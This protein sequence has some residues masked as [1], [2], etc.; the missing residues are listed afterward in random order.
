MLA[1]A[2]LNAS[3]SYIALTHEAV[4]RHPQAQA[5]YDAIASDERVQQA[6]EHPH[7]AA[8]LAH[9]HLPK[10]GRSLG[11]LLALGCAL[12]LL[13][14]M[15]GCGGRG[16]RRTDAM[17]AAARR[18]K[19]AA[20]K[21][22]QARQRALAKEQA[23]KRVAPG[24][25][26]GVSEAALKSED[27][28]RGPST[29][30]LVTGAL[31]LPVRAVVGVARAVLRVVGLLRGGA[32]RDA[33]DDE[34]DDENDDGEAPPGDEPSAA[35]GGRSAQT[36]A[37]AKPRAKKES[38]P[39]HPRL[40]ST[41]KGF[42]EGV[43]SAALSADGN[44]ALAVGPDRTM[45]IYTG[46]RAV[47]GQ[48]TLPAPL[49]AK[50]PLDHGSACALSANGRNC[51]VATAASRK[52]LAYTITPPGTKQAK[53]GLAFRKEFPTGHAGAV[54]EVL[55]APNSRFIVTVG[56][57]DDRAVKLWSV[58]GEPLGSIENKQAEQYSASISADSR[59]VAVAAS[60]HKGSHAASRS[61]APRHGQ[62]SLFE[63]LGAG[64]DGAPTGIRL[65]TSVAGHARG[66]ASVS[67]AQDC[68]HLALACKDGAWS[69]VATSARSVEPREV[70]RG[71][72]PG[73]PFERIA[74]SPFA[75]RLIGATASTLTIIDTAAAARGQH[76]VIDTVT[77]TGHGGIT[78][79][80]FS[81][82]GL[83]A[84]SGG[85]DGWLRLWQVE[86]D[87]SKA[88]TL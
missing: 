4:R 5:A 85:Q 78:A 35:A 1:A 18:A 15:C 72:A 84:L 41:L 64:A 33:D 56:G 46:L 16:S 51:V 7:V 55:L 57:G 87:E 20:K 45:R 47:G 81:N 65:E 22:R 59:L 63:V 58:A 53:A 76:G 70:A 30:A 73:P 32:S 27:E 61:V 82:D 8:T 49:M 36:G 14:C 54:A 79:L 26:R 75:K 21:E 29:F 48:A 34:S 2:A 66:I 68:V 11:G 83:W 77:A 31:L 42:S 69:L 19:T 6:M 44:L 60:A 10:L 23:A 13:R 9:A 40:M 24:R 37:R 67:F 3:E 43:S 12:L 80:A 28:L 71:V 50:V 38:G 88:G 52:L 86:A 62:V 25:L 17:D 74:L 39:S